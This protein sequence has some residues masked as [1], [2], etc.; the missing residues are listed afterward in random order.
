MSIVNL[1]TSSFSPSVVFTSL[2]EFFS[3]ERGLLKKEDISDHFSEYLRMYFGGKCAC[4][5]RLRAHPECRPQAGVSNGD[6]MAIK[7]R[8]NMDDALK[9]C[10]SRGFSL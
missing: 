7:E 5:A 6:P 2:P 9:S 8:A 3:F 4:L 1:S 10:V